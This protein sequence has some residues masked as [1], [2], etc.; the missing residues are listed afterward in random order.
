[1]QDYDVIVIGAGCG[2]LTAAALL[3]R[4]GRRTL[5]LEQSGVVGGCCSTYVKEGY[6][7]DVGA[8]I[9]EITFPMEIAFAA[10]GTSLHAALELE[11]LDPVYG[12]IFRDG[13]RL[14][15]PASVEEKAQVIEALSPLD[16][17]NWLRYAEYFK[18]F[19][20]HA[21]R[22]FYLN[23]ANTLT[24]MAKIF[25]KDPGFLRFAP[26]FM[27]SFEDVLRKYFRSD[28]VRESMTY[29]GFFAGLPPALEPAILSIL[30]Y[31]E[32]EGSYHPKGGMGAL[33]AAL[34][35]L[36]EAG[37]L[38]LRLNQRVDRVLVRRRR[39]EGVR[40]ADGTEITSRVVISNINAKQLY[41]EMIG[42]EELPW[43]AR[44]GIKS[45]KLSV[46]AP[47]LNVGLDARPALDAHHTV[48]SA[49]A[50]ALNEY[51][52]GGMARGQ[53]PQQQFSLI[54]F[55]TYSDASMAPE[56]HHVLNIILGGPYAR[57]DGDWER[58]KQAYGEQ[59]LERLSETAVPGLADHVQL[60][61]VLTPRDYEKRLLMPEGAILGLQMD[62]AASAAFRPSARSKSIEG[63]FLAG[64]S[65]HPGGG[66][67]S[68][69]ASGLIAA[70]LVD[71]D[72]RRHLA[73]LIAEG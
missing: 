3:A 28:K 63:L 33:P 47:M 53:L 51:W 52:Y 70:G 6:S 50:E 65:T 46:S 26:L 2:G 73:G 59:Q 42:E 56:G 19:L 45:Y 22:G 1:M 15:Y 27:L 54:S 17:D 43:I 41:L 58:D 12:I 68:V 18:R 64:S 14:T 35:R 8:T 5:V 44:Y 66:V 21:L 61:Q 69:I 57:S 25:V 23:P 40:L 7:F 4:A 16:R 49:P 72:V 37:G 32:H 34:L 71:G 11:P 10:L 38:E 39:C 48:L 24:D 20:H 55:P 62:L 67:P 9:L 13:S 36:G 30:S 31:A 29:Q 60:L